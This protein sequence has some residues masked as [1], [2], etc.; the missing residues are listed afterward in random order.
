MRMS[1]TARGGAW[2]Y[3][4]PVDDNAAVQLEH[5]ANCRMYV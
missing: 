1:A 5:A 2:C 4:W 3:S